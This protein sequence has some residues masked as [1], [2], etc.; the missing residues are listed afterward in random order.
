MMKRLVVVVALVVFAL[1]IRL[2]V[3]FTKDRSNISVEELRKVYAQAKT[4]EERRAVALTAMDEG[5]INRAAS[6]EVVDRIFSFDLSAEKDRWIL[7]DPW[8][9][10]RETAGRSQWDKFRVVA[11]GPAAKPVTADTHWYFVAAKEPGGGVLRSE[12]CN[13]QSLWGRVWR[14]PA[15]RP[16][17]YASRSRTAEPEAVRE[18]TTEVIAKLNLEYRNARD[19][20]A[21]AL[22]SIDTGLIHEGA[23]VTVVDK[24]FGTKCAK[25][26]S[27]PCMVEFL[28][29]PWYLMLWLHEGKIVCY[30]LSNYHIKEPAQSPGSSS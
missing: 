28:R 6:I 10:A 9:E 8:K 2:S 5:A 29:G 16:E 23:P 12:L 15:P 27:N 13:C 19:R 18:S 1:A 21:V 26:E 4:L 20:R 3:G 7:D 30:S 14:P 11:L 17:P 24:I 25:E 22:R